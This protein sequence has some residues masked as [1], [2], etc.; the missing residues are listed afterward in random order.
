MSGVQN[1]TRSN[2][3]TDCDHTRPMHS[4][5]PKRSCQC[6]AGKIN[7]PPRC[8]HPLLPMLVEV[9]WRCQ[10]KLLPGAH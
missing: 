1:R 9:P 3:N 2:T 5:T 7:A 6:N 10:P 8:Y 4:I